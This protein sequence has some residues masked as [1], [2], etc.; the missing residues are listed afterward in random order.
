MTSKG[1]KTSK[2]GPL[3]GTKVGKVRD[4]ER[5]GDDNASAGWNRQSKKGLATSKNDQKASR[6]SLTKNEQHSRMHAATNSK[7][8]EQI[9]HLR[10]RSKLNLNS[11]TMINITVSQSGQK[12]DASPAK[13][14]NTN[15]EDGDSNMFL[16]L[17]EKRSSNMDAAAPR[18]NPKYSTEPKGTRFKH[19]FDPSD[20]VSEGR[21]T[22][23]G[24]QFQAADHDQKTEPAK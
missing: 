13:S 17:Q 3:S 12:E 20:R 11:N 4:N 23:E 9:K 16:K 2:E 24:A 10:N 8:T 14:T 18:A 6:A 5:V 7:T 19:T 1:G 22:P 15:Q 21:D